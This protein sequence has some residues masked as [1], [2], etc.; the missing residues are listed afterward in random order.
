MQL[1]AAAMRLRECG[2]A[3][4][5]VIQVLAACGAAGCKL[6]P[7]ADVHSARGRGGAS[8]TCVMLCSS[9]HV[10]V[11]LAITSGCSR[12]RKA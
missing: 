10:N 8:H 1:L 11:H 4:V 5:C 7:E 6:E 9:L 3:D 2:R 12:L